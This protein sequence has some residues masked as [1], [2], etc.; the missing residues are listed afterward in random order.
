MRNTFPGYY[1]PTDEEFSKMWQECIFV[2]DANV[3][4]NIYRYTPQTRDDLLDIFQQLRERIWIPHQAMLEYHENREG[5]IAKQYAIGSEIEEVLQRALSIINEYKKRGHPFVDTKSI[6][7]I[8]A[9]A[10]KKIHTAVNEAQAQQPNLLEQDAL[11]EQMTKLFDGRVGEKYPPKRLD[12]VYNEL[13][14]RYKLHIPPGYKDTKKDG[15]YDKY[16]DGLVWYQILDYAQSH[17]KPIILTIDDVKE[18]WWKKANGKT[19]G[20]RPELVEEML[21]KAGVQ[22]YMYNTSQFM[23]YAKEFLSVRVKQQTIDEVGSLEQQDKEEYL[24]NATVINPTIVKQIIDAQSSL[25]AIPVNVGT[26]LAE[27]RKAA[28]LIDMGIGKQASDLIGAYNSRIINAAIEPL[29]ALNLAGTL[30][31]TV[32]LGNVES[33]QK[34]CASAVKSMALLGLLP[35]QKEESSE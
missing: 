3:L 17:K 9:D 35:S 8:I 16:G 26:Y 21:S 12:E 22:F 25:N 4:L 7:E 31:D 5:V 34:Q 30:S 1:R 32:T 27:A 6:E 2:F 15:L 28:E 11:L 14:L 10:I 19:D 23:K 24:A 13:A 20:P 18:D 33:L 29:K